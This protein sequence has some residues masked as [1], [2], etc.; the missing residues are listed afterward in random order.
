ME[1]KAE[2]VALYIDS[3]SPTFDALL[4]LVRCES[5]LVNPSIEVIS[6]KL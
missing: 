3:Q 2:R 4:A 6:F 1:Y 5:V